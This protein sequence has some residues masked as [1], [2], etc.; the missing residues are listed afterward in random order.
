MSFMKRF[1]G[2]TMYTSTRKKPELIYDGAVN[3][4]ETLYINAI[5][6]SIYMVVQLPNGGSTTVKCY[7]A[8]TNDGTTDNTEETISFILNST[9]KIQES[10]LVLTL[11]PYLKITIE[12]Q[13]P[14]E[15]KIWIDYA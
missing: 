9:E 4:I 15:I 8:L 2:H 11:A 7:Q 6:E 3:G 1:D 12:S 5:S 14:T 10:D 13:T